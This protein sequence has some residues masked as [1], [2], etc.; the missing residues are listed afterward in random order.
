MADVKDFSVFLMV[1]ASFHY[2]LSKCRTVAEFSRQEIAFSLSVQRT[3]E[4]FWGPGKDPKDRTYSQ[5][6]EDPKDETPSYNG[7]SVASRD[8]FLPVNWMKMQSKPFEPTAEFQNVPGFGRTSAC[9][10]EV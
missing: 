4:F 5:D 6:G 9:K 10:E 1:S 2:M 7:L 8:L 3:R